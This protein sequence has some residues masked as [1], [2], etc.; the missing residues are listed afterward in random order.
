MNLVIELIIEL[1][2]GSYAMCTHSLR[3]KS[4]RDWLEDKKSER[5]NGLPAC[6]LPGGYATCAAFEPRRLPTVKKLSTPVLD[7]LCFWISDISIG[8]LENTENCFPYIFFSMFHQH[9]SA[10]HCIAYTIL[11]FLSLS[12][13]DIWHNHSKRHPNYFFLLSYWI[14]IFV[15]VEI[16]WSAL[17]SSL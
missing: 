11:P 10:D 16:S 3:R 5:Q 15:D 2:L 17:D 1:N 7:W 13:P 4:I 6:L 8:C 12:L 14:F 9:I